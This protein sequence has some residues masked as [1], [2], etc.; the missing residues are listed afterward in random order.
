MLIPCAST[1][2]HKVETLLLKELLKIFDISRFL[3]KTFPSAV[4]LFI[5][6]WEIL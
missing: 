1:R 5:S 4:K 3:P 2:L 6:L